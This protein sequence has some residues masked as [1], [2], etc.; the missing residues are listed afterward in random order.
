MNL[1]TRKN[2][3]IALLENREVQDRLCALCGTVANK[4]KFKA[5][6][7]NIALDSSL[8]NC[9]IQSIIKASLDVAGLKL[10]LN[11][12]LGKAY[13]VPRNIRNGNEYTTEAR[14]D[15]GY[16][17]WLELAKRSGLSVKSY[18]VFNCDNFTYEVNGINET[19]RLI[20]NFDKRQDFD[21]DWIKENLTGIIVGVKDL[22]T[23]DY[24]LK[25]VSK[26]TLFKIMQQNESVKK[27]RYSA[28]SDW[29]LEMFMAK[30]IKTCL[31]KTAMSDELGLAV[32]Y[33][34]ASDSQDFNYET[35]TQNQSTQTKKPNNNSFNY[36][37]FIQ[38]NEI[39][40]KEPERVLT[41]ETESN[42]DMPF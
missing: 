38:S 23:S 13:I 10:S 15:I 20:P 5:T 9:S 34:N 7:L 27:G 42:N 32:Y 24:S 36:D 6:L 40:K 26:G 3:A 31:S 35:E 19:M 37:L 39:I 41:Q 17:G 25:F 4:D 14:I 22:R 18:S 33:D 1:Q 2:E 11:K 8:S 21:S 30:A 12:N 16:K 28:Y 29:M